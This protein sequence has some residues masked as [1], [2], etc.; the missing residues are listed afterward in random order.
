MGVWACPEVLFSRTVDAWPVPVADQGAQGERIGALVVWQTVS[1]A[2]EPAAVA[3]CAEVV[4][5][6]QRRPVDPRV[7]FHLGLANSGKT[8]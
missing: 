3:E 6:G 7:T 2:V 1:M 4:D 5:V 8:H